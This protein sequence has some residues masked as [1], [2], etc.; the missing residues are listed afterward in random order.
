MDSYPTV[1]EALVFLPFVL[2]I[3]LWVAWS[4]MA[5]MKIPNKAV[6]RWRRSGR[7]WAGS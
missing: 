1:R 4:D 7:F 5:R 2:P 3:A 6:L